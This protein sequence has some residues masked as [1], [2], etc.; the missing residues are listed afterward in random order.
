MISKGFIY[1]LGLGLLFLVMGNAHAWRMDGGV[2]CD[3]NQ[4]GYI[5]AGDRPLTDFGN[6]AVRINVINSTGGLFT[7]ATYPDGYYNIPLPDIE[8]SYTA[9]IDASTLPADATIVQP[10]EL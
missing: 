8:D 1:T 9:T 2:V 5:D 7:G 3:V 10:S 6:P 4:S